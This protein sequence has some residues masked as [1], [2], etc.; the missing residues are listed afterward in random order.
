MIRITTCLT[1]RGMYNYHYI[2]MMLVRCRKM[3]RRAGPGPNPVTL[4]SKAHNNIMGPSQCLPPNIHFRVAVDSDVTSIQDVIYDRLYARS[5]WIVSTS[6]ASAFRLNVN[7][8]KVRI[9]DPDIVPLVV[10]A[11]VDI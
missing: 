4:L 6:S 5:N 1:T 3:A 2:N 11:D 9:S 8:V 7:E 10:F